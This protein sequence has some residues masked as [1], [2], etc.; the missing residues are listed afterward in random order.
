MPTHSQR[1]SLRLLLRWSFPG[2]SLIFFLSA[3]SIW[4]LLAEMY[5]LC[6]MRFFTLAILIPATILLILIAIADYFAGD[7]RLSR[8]VLVGSLAGLLAAVAYDVFR[9]PFVFAHQWHL[10][11]YIPAMNL[12]KPFPRFG[13]MI[14]NQPVEQPSYSLLTHLVGW[15]YHFSNGITFGIMYLAIV[16]NPARRSWLWA[17]ALAAGLELA[18][19]FTPYPG[20][21]AITV[22]AAFV[23]VTLSAHILFGIVLGLTSRRL[24]AQS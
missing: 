9:L 19:L 7:K 2:R 24:S 15:I 14:L 4:C 5:H 21:F 22:T 1:D 20:F 17:I 8:A 11:P 13:A 6:S 10:A 16:G 18:M 3:M 12:Y 23:A